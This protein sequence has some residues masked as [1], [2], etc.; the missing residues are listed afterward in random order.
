MP[1]PMPMPTALSLSSVTTLFNQLGRHKP[2]PCL[3]RIWRCCPNPTTATSAIWAR[4]ER[5]SS[6]SP[7]SPSSFSGAVCGWR[8]WESFGDASWR[9]AWT[10]LLLYHAVRRL[11]FLLSSVFFVG[12]DWLQRFLRDR[13]SEG[14]AAGTALPSDTAVSCNGAASN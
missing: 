14:P 4:G 9:R 1:M 7:P 8:P 10:P 6:T 11:H 3:R 13:F 12:R 2:P 5:P